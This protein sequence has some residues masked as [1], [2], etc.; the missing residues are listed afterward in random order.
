MDERRRRKALCNALRA[1]I[2]SIVDDRV[3]RIPIYERY[4]DTIQA[5]GP[6][7]IYASGR[8]QDV[9]YRSNAQ[10]IGSLPGDVVTA[11][12]E[13]YANVERFRSRV[14]A[15]ERLLERYGAGADKAVDP[16][17]LVSLFQRTIE[18]MGATV[19]QGRTLSARLSG[20][21]NVSPTAG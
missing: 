14:L 3:S 19:N 13:F 9:V 10:Q 7:S 4:I 1:E 16:Q 15:I 20:K 12:V 18:I 8:A 11:V 21:K 2:D 6:V 5:G 17:Y